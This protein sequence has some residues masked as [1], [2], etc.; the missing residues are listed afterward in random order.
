LACSI[1]NLQFDIFVIA[2]NR[3]ESKIDANSGH[4][5]FIELI[6]SKSKQQAAFADG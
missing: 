3:F 2:G 1:P 6:V 5:V 4:V